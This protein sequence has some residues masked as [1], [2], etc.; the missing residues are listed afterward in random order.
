MLFCLSGKD[1]NRVS[2]HPWR[3]GC[4]RIGEENKNSIVSYYF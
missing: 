4:N 2:E 3:L 1:Q